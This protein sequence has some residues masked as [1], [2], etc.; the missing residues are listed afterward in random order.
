[1]TTGARQAKDLRGFG[2]PDARF[3]YANVTAADSSYSEAGPRPGSPV[4]AD[5]NS[6]LRLSISGEQSVGLT[7]IVTRAGM[8][9]IDLGG[10]RLGY[11]KTSESATSN[12]GWNAPNLI[13]GFVAAEYSATTCGAPDAA[14]IPSSSAVVAVYQRG[15]VINSNLW[16]ADAWTW[17]GRQTVID[18]GASGGVAAVLCIP[19]G[20]ERLLCI[21]VG[22]DYLTGVVHYSDDG[23]T[24]GLW[25][26]GVL[27]EEP[28]TTTRLRARAFYGDGDVGFWLVC[29][30]AGTTTVYHYGST[31]LGASFALVDT[32]AVGASAAAPDF[33]QLADGRMGAVYVKVATGLLYLR[34]TATVWDAFGEDTTAIHASNTYSECSAY[35]DYDGAIYV[36]A[37]SSTTADHWDA[38]RSTDGGDSFTQF[39]WGLYD[40]N[41]PATYPTK[42]K[43][44][45]CAGY[46][47]IVHQWVATP[48]TFDNSIAMM[49]AGGW[50][51][52]EM[53][54]GY[55]SGVVDVDIRRAGSGPTSVAVNNSVTWLPY[56][57]PGDVAGWA[58]TGGG[59]D[60]LVV[61]AGVG[62]IDTGGAERSFTATS[63]SA[64]SRSVVVTADLA[65]S[66]GGSLLQ[67]NVGFRLTTSTGGTA[68]RVDVCATKT[69]FAIVDSSG[70]LATIAADLETEYIQIRAALATTSTATGGHADVAY[71]R[72]G[73]AV[74]TSAYSGAVTALGVAPAAGSTAVWG[75]VTS[76]SAASNWA[77]VS[78]IF[79][80]TVSASVPL[81]THP[82]SVDTWH[83]DLAGKALN[84]FAYPLADQAT[85]GTSYLRALSGPGR[86]AETHSI[87]VVNDY[88][89]ERVFWEV[90][91]SPDEV[92]RSTST[93]EQTIGFSLGIDSQIGKSLAVYFGGVNFRTAYLERWDGAAWQIMGTYDGSTGFVTSLTSS[94]S[95]DMIRPNVA[96]TAAA[97]RYIQRGEFIGATIVS[98]GVYHEIA[99]HSEGNWIPTTSGTGKLAEF[100][101]ASGTPAAGA[102]SIIARHGVLIVHNVTTYD[103]KFRI[104]IPSQTTKDNYFELGTLL[105]TQVQPLGK[106]WDWGATRERRTSVEET[107]SRRGTA[108]RRKL[109]PPP[110]AWTVAWSDGVDMSRLRDSVDLDWLS[111]KAGYSPLVNQHDVA[112]LLSG[113][114]DELQAGEVPA[115][116]LNSIPDAATA[117]STTITDQTR[118]CY[119]YLTGS[120]STDLVVGDE[121]ESELVRVDS[122][123]IERV[124]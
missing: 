45:G 47:G 117:D 20:T 97:G 100:R 85:A 95:G 5:A 112:W 29:D 79:G 22:T 84:A 114:L 10:G 54:P 107:T 88:G 61:D 6:K 70:N 93:A 50:S 4:A 71:R 15:N 122:I 111:A 67:P 110:E 12:R 23:T 25:N 86:V 96:T 98:N 120:V 90:S 33:V 109:G 31:N 81:W 77:L 115:L 13:N 9:A 119:G 37:R 82:A 34:R 121:G 116:L 2:I 66:L 49:V 106:Q 104:R 59:S 11:R 102:A 60:E 51:S 21:S 38:Y 58:T 26:S 43:V 3:S 30:V 74:W 35:V 17:A 46:A 83:D 52:F 42:M 72:R 39:K 78:V 62:L 27:P 92:W 48:G 75:H 7:A 16:D 91:P 87:P 118:F 40:G 94:V 89:I 19:G 73:A 18:L 68:Y 103:D 105:I 76:S 44:V 101:V 80:G 55:V 123:S 56:D 53:A 99:A 57:A 32:W 63:L 36:Y 1:M 14:V 41:E 108:R 28:T 8:P 124:L 64:S 113:I 65:V 24:W 69:G